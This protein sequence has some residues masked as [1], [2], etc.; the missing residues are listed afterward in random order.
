VT[1]CQHLATAATVPT[2]ACNRAS[3]EAW[4]TRSP[5]PLNISS[6][7]HTDL[8]APWEIACPQITEALD[9]DQVFI[10]GRHG[11]AQDTPHTCPRG[12][13][14]APRTWIELSATL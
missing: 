14:A 13:P 5:A 3:E 10:R 2:D 9:R 7:D 12:A 1:E 6:T 11:A 8:A 4:R